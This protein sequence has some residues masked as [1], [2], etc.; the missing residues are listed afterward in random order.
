VYNSGLYL[1]EPFNIKIGFGPKEV[2]L[3]ILPAD[4][5]YYKVIY[6][7]GIIGAV[8]LEN[9]VNCWEMLAEGEYD[10][11]GLPYYQHNMNS[12]RIKVVLDDIT[13]DHIGEEIENKIQDLNDNR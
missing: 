6:Y 8:R 7:G 2:T 5:G 10:A 3:T 4:E 1:M 9:G 13:V 12:D 11:G